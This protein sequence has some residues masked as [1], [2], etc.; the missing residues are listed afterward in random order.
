MRD[1]LFFGVGCLLCVFASLLIGGLF[2]DC[3]IKSE[4]F[5]ALFWALQGLSALQSISISGA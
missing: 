5:V 2:S 1:I 4:G 3:K